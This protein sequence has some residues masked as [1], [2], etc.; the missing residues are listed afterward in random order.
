LGS[1]LTPSV[2]QCAKK[3]LGSK[4]FHSSEY[5]QH[6]H[7]F[8]AKSVAVIG[9]GQSAAEIILHL[10]RLDDELPAKINWIFA[11]NNILPMD[12]TAFTSEI[13]SP[14]YA[15]HFYNLPKEKRARLL[16]EQVLSSD[17]VSEQLISAIYQRLYVLDNLQQTP[18]Q[19]SLLPN[20]KL[21]NIKESHDYELILSERSESNIVVAADIIILCTGYKWE[22]PSYLKA[23]KG[24]IPLENEHFVVNKD[25]SIQWDGPRANRIY[26]QNAATH[27][28]GIADRNLSL[29]AWRS[30]NI[31]NSIAGE[32]V[33]DIENESAAID[34]QYAEAA[35][36]ND[37][38]YVSNA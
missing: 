36:T 1:G 4:V 30:A 25:Y 19:F 12:N 33:Y 28:H 27:S 34:W 14:G 31:I 16:Q 11:N 32:P 5:L 3:Y 2:P 18:L 8:K 35:R 15:R 23:L 37:W 24:R 26:V 20:I 17:G 9:G 29:M 7:E 6:A 38:R 22:F 13:Y 21:I 10:L